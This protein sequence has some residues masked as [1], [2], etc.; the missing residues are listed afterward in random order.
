MEKNG[1]MNKRNICF[2]SPLFMGERGKFNYSRING[3]EGRGNSFRGGRKAFGGIKGRGEMEKE[4][5]RGRNRGKR[6]GENGNGGE[7]IGKGIPSPLPLFRKQK[8]PP[9]PLKII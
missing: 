4:A 3:S 2:P 1:S 9:S 8:F 6:K 7:E 5:F